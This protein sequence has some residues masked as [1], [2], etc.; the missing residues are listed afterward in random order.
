MV[1][2]AGSPMS[3]LWANDITNPLATVEAILCNTPMFN[4]R[5]AVKNDNNM[6]SSS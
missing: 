2:L 1:I 4:A 5:E 6:L 3:K